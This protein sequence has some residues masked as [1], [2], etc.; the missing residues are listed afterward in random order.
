MLVLS[1][2]EN[3]IAAQ[4]YKTVGSNLHILVS[5][6]HLLLLVAVYKYIFTIH[7]ASLMGRRG[8]QNQLEFDE[9]EIFVSRFQLIWNHHAPGMVNV[10]VK[11]NHSS[12]E[13]WL[14]RF[15]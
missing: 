7:A 1:K 11:I 4:F 8:L 14:D 12:S 2:N 3:F 5:D 6:F 15:R 9:R 13:Q 10:Y